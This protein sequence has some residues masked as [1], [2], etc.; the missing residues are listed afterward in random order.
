MSAAAIVDYEMGGSAS[1]DGD[2]WM[3]C[4]T[5]AHALD[6]YIFVTSFA[7][8]HGFGVDKPRG[9]H[10]NMETVCRTKLSTKQIVHH[11]VM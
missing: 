6:D 4:A 2:E 3:G 11:D 7:P 8:V 9:M 5:G 1:A 10:T